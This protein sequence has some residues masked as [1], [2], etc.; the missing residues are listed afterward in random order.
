MPLPAIVLSLL[1]TIIEKVF[2]RESDSVIQGPNSSRLIPAR[3][4]L[5]RSK[6]AQVATGALVGKLLA[7]W[8]LPLPD[9]ALW[10][11]S[12]VILVEWAGSIVLRLK[13]KEGV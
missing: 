12:A 3:K 6:T 1:P 9:R 2:G 13:T 4:G 8:V 5:I 10:A 11:L 7:L